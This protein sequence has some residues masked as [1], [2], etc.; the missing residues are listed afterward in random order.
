VIGKNVQKT[1]SSKMYSF[2]RGQFLNSFEEEKINCEFDP[3][4][5]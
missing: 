4:S 1:M 5:E 3:G 2:F